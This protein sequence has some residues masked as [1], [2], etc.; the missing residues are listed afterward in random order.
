MKKKPYTTA[1]GLRINVD[2]AKIITV[3]HRVWP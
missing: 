3:G 2:H 1:F